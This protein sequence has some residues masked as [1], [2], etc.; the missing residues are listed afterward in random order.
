VFQRDLRPELPPIPDRREIACESSQ[1]GASIEH[2]ESCHFWFFC[3]DK[4]STMLL[5]GEQ[6][7]FDTIS[8]R[9]AAQNYAACHLDNPT[10]MLLKIVLPALKSEFSFL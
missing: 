1:N 8:K 2:P 10:G 5:C 9:C 3:R 4:K 6:T 7:V